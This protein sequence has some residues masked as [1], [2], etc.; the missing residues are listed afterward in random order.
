MDRQD[1]GVLDDCPVPVIF[2]FADP[3]QVDFLKNAKISVIKK[4]V[5]T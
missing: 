2:I 3:V 4:D 1:A 5:D